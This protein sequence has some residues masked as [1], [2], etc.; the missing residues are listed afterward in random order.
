MNKIQ[1]IKSTNQRV[2][3][4]Q[5]K[6]IA[7]EIIN[8]NLNTIEEYIKLLTYKNSS[9]D[10]TYVRTAA[11]KIIYYASKSKPNLITNF[12]PLV[13]NGL[14]APENS[15]QYRVIQICINCMKVETF[16]NEKIVKYCKKI[17]KC[18]EEHS[19]R[20]CCCVNKFLGLYGSKSLSHYSKVINIL[21]DSALNLVNELEISSIVESLTLLHPYYDGEMKLKLRNIIMNYDF[22]VA[23]RIITKKIYNLERLL[24]ES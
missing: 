16:T 20:Q 17:I 23:N 5:C 24:S 18:K 19:I 4:L 7:S 12:I 3:N 22:F 1:V 21:Y 2:S 13:I 9:P 14:D 8:D 10:G 15:L 6:L 11:S